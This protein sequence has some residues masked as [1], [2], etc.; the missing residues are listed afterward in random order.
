[1]L[2]IIPRLTQGTAASSPAK[3]GFYPIKKRAV[4]LVVNF[5]GGRYDLCVKA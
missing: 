3:K 2:K 4:T 5:A 1:M